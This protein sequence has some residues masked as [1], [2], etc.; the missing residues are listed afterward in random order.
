MIN[1][2]LALQEKGYLVKVYTPFFDPQRCFKEAREELDVEVR[3]GIWPRTI[4]GRFTA[5]CAYIRMIL[6]ALYVTLFAGHFDYIILD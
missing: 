5:M 4:C 6:C 3:G 1:I 2:G